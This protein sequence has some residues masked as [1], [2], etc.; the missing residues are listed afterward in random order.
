MEYNLCASAFFAEPLLL[1]CYMRYLMRCVLIIDSLETVASPLFEVVVC[2]FHLLSHLFECNVMS[3]EVIKQRATTASTWAGE[4]ALNFTTT[5]TTLKRDVNRAISVVE[6]TRG[7]PTMVD[8]L[9]R[10]GVV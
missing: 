1:G 6:N 2:C 7:T 5:Q 10:S 4:S 8:V 9:E 3:N